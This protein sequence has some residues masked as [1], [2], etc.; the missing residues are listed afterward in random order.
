MA[1]LHKL[2]LQR[3]GGDGRRSVVTDRDEISSQAD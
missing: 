2:Q 1:G 3:E